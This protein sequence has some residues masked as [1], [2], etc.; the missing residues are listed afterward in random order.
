[1]IRKAASITGVFIMINW[2]ILFS[3]CGHEYYPEGPEFEAHISRPVK[4]LDTIQGSYR[5]IQGS[6]NNMETVDQIES[7]SFDSLSDNGQ[8][9]L[10]IPS[11]FSRDLAFEEGSSYT[12]YYQ[13]MY[14]W[15]SVY[16]LVVLHENDVVF[17]GV[18]DI[19]INYFIKPQET[20]YPAFNE[21]FRVEQTAVLNDRFITS[22]QCYDRITNT[23][24]TVTHNGDS[25]TLH[26]GQ[27]GQ[28]GDFRVELNIARE[29][30]YAEGCFD[31]VLTGI[32]YIITKFR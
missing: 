7:Y 6:Y 19:F 27:S 21:L 28:L 23:E 3:A 10:K 17:I 5:I 25:I 12:L 29:V 2:L 32:S 14:G 26:Q 22:R 16:G 31:S 9:E 13:V 18:T 24:V 30:D 8:F 1:M 11:A 4:T 15:P 20:L